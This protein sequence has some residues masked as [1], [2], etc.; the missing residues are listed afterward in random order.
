[1]R[2]TAIELASAMGDVRAVKLLHNFGGKRAM[3]QAL[4]LR[5]AQ[6]HSLCN[7]VKSHISLELREQVFCSTTVAGTT[8]LEAWRACIHC[9]SPVHMVRQRFTLHVRTDSLRSALGSE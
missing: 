1:M 4:V 7:A 2:N 8:T 6:L 3:H 5:S 9:I